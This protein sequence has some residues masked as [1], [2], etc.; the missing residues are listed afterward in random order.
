[1][2]VADIIKYMTISIQ[3]VNDFAANIL[4]NDKSNVFDSSKLHKLSKRCHN[5]KFL[6][7]PSFHQ[8]AF[9]K[10]DSRYLA[11]IARG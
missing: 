3:R 9:A 1:M 11:R 10:R 6:Y 8:Y 5:S 4:I 2:M 7:L